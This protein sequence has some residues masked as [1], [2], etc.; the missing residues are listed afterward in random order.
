VLVARRHNCSL[1]GKTEFA[2][3]PESTPTGKGGINSQR[4]AGCRR[5]IFRRPPLEQVLTQIKAGSGI[6][7]YGTTTG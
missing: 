3:G 5:G 1:G 4:G 6:A 2:A 7:L